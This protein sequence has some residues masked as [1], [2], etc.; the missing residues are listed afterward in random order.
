M[1]LDRLIA[2]LSPAEVRNAASVEIRNLAMDLDAAGPGSLFFCVPGSRVDGHELAGQA[3]AQGAAAL[4]VE[5]PLAA[6]VPQL[7]VPSVR[8]AMPTAAVE[9]FGDPSR[10]LPVA[11]VTGTNGKTT[12]AFLLHSILATAGRRPA[13]LTNI[14]RRVAGESRPVGLNTPEAID[15]Q[16]LFREML[17]RG[18]QS[19]VMEATSIA[20]AKGRL[21]GTRFAVLVFTNLTQDHLDFHGSME[22]YFAAKRALFAQAE[23][24]VVNID[25]PWGTRLAAELR[26]ARTFTADDELGDIEPRL[27][28]RFNRANTLAAVWAARELGVDEDAIRDGIAALEGVPGRFE[29]IDEGQPFAVIVD[30]AH[31]PDSLVNVLQ[32]ARELGDGR[33]I[34]V[35]GAGGDRDR[36]KRPLMGQAG[37]DHADR[38][39]IT[40]DNPR[41]EDPAEIAVEVAGRDLEVILDRREAIETAIAAAR[42]G[43]VVVIAGKGADAAIEL[44]DRLVPFD[45]RLVARDV[46]RRVTAR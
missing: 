32:A 25:D 5:R 16:R 27:R 28:G 24:A 12:T 20:Q 26:D 21:A 37:R 1:K 41:S 45:D 9:F 4:A 43:D 8:E 39:I 13:L 22:E 30:Y 42:P 46:L 33:V 7:V 17:E 11:G 6:D 2:V 29:A 31:T 40:T 14:E 18:D 36:G 3:V 35:Y 44:A 10:E 38:T 34:A 23:R 19:C 15:L